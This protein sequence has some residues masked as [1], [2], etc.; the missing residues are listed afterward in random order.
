MINQT[1]ITKSWL[2]RFK[3]SCLDESLISEMEYDYKVQKLYEGLIHTT[4][5]SSSIRILNS[6]YNYLSCSKKN[7]TIELLI[8]KKNVKFI[9]SNFNL[10]LSTINNLGWFPAKI[11]YLTDKVQR[12]KWSALIVN[13]I[14]ELVDTYS[15]IQIVLEAKYDLE[16]DIPNKVYHISPYY[17][18]DKIQK[19][20]LTP[21]AKNKIS[22]HPD[23]IYFSKT[24]E[25]AK[26]LGRPIQKYLK[27]KENKFVIYE[28]NTDGIDRLF[29]DP[30]FS[31]GY[32][33]LENIHPKNIKIIEIIEL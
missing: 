20:G 29:K 2:K 32:Y 1:N 12:K 24:I 19:Y 25:D 13:Q 27:V 33:T 22:T 9:L 11:I 21:K 18:K 23:R 8:N 7:N 4:D 5:I 3:R 15:Y 31:N 10:I 6:T 14:L 26:L 16:V 17:N 30:N 28:I